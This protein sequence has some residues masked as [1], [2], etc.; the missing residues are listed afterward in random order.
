ME[1]ATDTPIDENIFDLFETVDKKQFFSD[2]LDPDINFFK[3]LNITSK[4]YNNEEL[5]KL[6]ETSP[7][8]SFSILHINSRSLFH[9][10]PVLEVLCGSTRNFFSILLITETWLTE[11][12]APLI[13]LPGYTFVYRNRING[14]G[15]GVAIFIRDDLHFRMRYDLC[16]ANPVF[17]WLAIE[18]INQEGK[19]I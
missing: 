2:A 3:S 14:R 19:K 10:V 9:K 7:N 18:M 16:V 5:S 17:D 12:T 6:I 1:A 8:N 4:Y 15:G 11:D 13:I